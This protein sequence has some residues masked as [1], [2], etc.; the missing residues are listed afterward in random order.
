[1]TKRAVFSVHQ[2]DFDIL[3]PRV[4][5]GPLRPRHRVSGVSEPICDYFYESL[6]SWVHSKL[7]LKLAIRPLYPRSNHSGIHGSKPRSE[8]KYEDMGFR[9]RS[10]LKSFNVDREHEYS[11]RESGLSPQSPPIRRIASFSDSFECT[12]WF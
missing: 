5:M 10:S 6:N 8:P 9:S 11:C 2:P 3:S 7:S 1:M 4:D 12:Q